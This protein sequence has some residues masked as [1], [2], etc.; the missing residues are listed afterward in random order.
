MSMLSMALLYFMLM[1]ARM[2]PALHCLVDDLGA[3]DRIFHAAT[4]PKLEHTELGTVYGWCQGAQF[5]NSA[6]C[7]LSTRIFHRTLRAPKH[8]RWR[9]SEPRAFWQHIRELWQQRLAF[10]DRF[11]TQLHV[12]SVFDTMNREKLCRGSKKQ[13]RFVHTLG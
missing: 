1:V 11:W 12:F 4:G 7:W 6:S 2:A 8:F 10:L 3:C 9:A 5:Y 13:P